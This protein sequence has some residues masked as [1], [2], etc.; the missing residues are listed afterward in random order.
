V[1]PY[2]E[3][4]YTDEL[5][6]DRSVHRRFSDGREEWR[7]RGERN[8]VHWRDNRGNFG[9]DELLGDGIVKR[10]YGTGQ[11]VYGREQ[12]YGRT[13][14]GNGHLTV[15]R[16]TFGGRMGVVLTAIGAGALLGALVAPPLMMRPEEELTLRQQQAQQ[17]S[18]S[19]D[20]GG[21]SGDGGGSSDSDWD[22]DDGGSGMDDD[23][24]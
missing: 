16:T 12:G 13:L 22:D 6:A 5:L 4:G 20:S 19:S 23:F 8:V 14:W 1:T 17:Q 9:V 21:G 24:G 7:R 11:V 15:N 18:S 2:V 3:I 10:Q